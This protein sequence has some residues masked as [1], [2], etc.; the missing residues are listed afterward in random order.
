MNERD[1][2]QRFMFEGLDIRGTLVRFEGGWQDMLRGRSYGR[3]PIRLLGE[4]SARIYFGSQDKQHFT[5]RELIN[6]DSPSEPIRGPSHALGSR[7][8]A[9]SVPGPAR[10]T[11]AAPR[12]SRTDEKRATARATSPQASWA[13]GGATDPARAVPLYL[14]NRVALTTAE[15]EARKAG[16]EPR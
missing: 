12:R 15:R 16:E 7:F 3:T 10:T 5:V 11:S 2:I 14:R 13:R 8:T 9:R 4:V 6:F 1:F